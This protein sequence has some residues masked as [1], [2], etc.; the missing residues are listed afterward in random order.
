MITNTIVSIWHENLLAGN[1]FVLKYNL[2]LRLTVPCAFLSEN[3]LLLA[4]DN[5]YRNINMIR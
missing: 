5:V 3:C 4:T 1:F 2:F